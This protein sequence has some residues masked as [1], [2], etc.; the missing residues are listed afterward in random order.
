MNIHWI[1]IELEVSPV[2][3]QKNSGLLPVIPP[4]APLQWEFQDPKMEVLCHI[5]PYF[6]GISPYIGLTKALHMVGTSNQSVPEMAIDP[7]RSQESPH[8][9]NMIKKKSVWWFQT[10]DY[11][12]SHWY[13][14]CH[15]SR[16][17]ELIFVKIVIAPPTR[18]LP[19]NPEMRDVNFVFKSLRIFFANCQKL[20]INP[21]FKSRWRHLDS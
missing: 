9:E 16:I 3:P 13:M 14:G 19:F 2:R 18:Y 1:S 12:F 15:P 4:L 10:M 5:R 20:Q 7:W 17:D 11:E 21:S 6:G 8:L